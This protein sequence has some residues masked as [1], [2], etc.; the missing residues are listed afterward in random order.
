MNNDLEIEKEFF[1][2]SEIMKILQLSRMTI[3]RYINNGKLQAYKFWK[4]YR[5]KNEDFEKFIKEHKN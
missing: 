5:V 4:D 1:T 3:Y 2:I